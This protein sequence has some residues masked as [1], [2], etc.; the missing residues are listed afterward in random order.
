[1]IAIYGHCV[2]MRDD[3]EKQLLDTIATLSKPS[4][5]LEVQC[6]CVQQDFKQLVSGSY[7]YPLCLS[8]INSPIG[9]RNSTGQQFSAART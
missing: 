7:P 6:I 8:C 2:L 3:Q 9:H 1:V 4:P 5:S